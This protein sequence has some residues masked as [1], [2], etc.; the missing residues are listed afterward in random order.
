MHCLTTYF[1][2]LSTHF[3][4][5]TTHSKFLKTH[6]KFFETHFKFTT[7][8]E[9]F[10]HFK[11]FTTHFKIFATH[12]EIFT[13]H[14]EIFTT[15][16]PQ[17]PKCWQRK[18]N[19]YAAPPSSFALQNCVFQN[20]HNR[21]ILYPEGSIFNLPWRFRSTKQAA[22]AFFLAYRFQIK[23]DRES[24][25]HSIITVIHFSRAIKLYKRFYKIISRNLFSLFF[26]CTSTTTSIPIKYYYK[27]TKYTSYYT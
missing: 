23:S 15:H 24:S 18:R 6:S 20:G 2:L 9:I 19:G 12:F 16:S 4:L 27:Y 25:I 17:D 22:E 3:K 26:F 7:N 8:S 11:I 14:F 5:C 1:E 21:W 10:T 13:T